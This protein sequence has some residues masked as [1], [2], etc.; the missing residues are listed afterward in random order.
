MARAP[1]VRHVVSNVY[2]MSTFHPVSPIGCRKMIR[3]LCASAFLA[4]R[5]ICVYF[6]DWWDNWWSWNWIY[7]YGMVMVMELA[8][9]GKLSA[10]GEISAS[11]VSLVFSY[12]LF[13]V[14]SILFSCLLLLVFFYFCLL[15]LRFDRENSIGIIED[16]SWKMISL[17]Y[18]A[19]SGSIGIFLVNI[20]WFQ[21]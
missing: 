20:T 9:M 5:D 1:R 8:R 4:N 3:I 7:G 18:Y 11:V 6:V 14:T 17:N 21:Q 16:G 19:A 15:L 2:T 13:V 10:M 12:F